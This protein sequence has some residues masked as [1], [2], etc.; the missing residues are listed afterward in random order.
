M[1]FNNNETVLPVKYLQVRIFAL[2][3]V[4]IFSEKK[5]KNVHC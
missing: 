4:S 1:S 2:L 3:L 5:K